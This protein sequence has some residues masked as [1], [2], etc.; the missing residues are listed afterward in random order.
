M[1]EALLLTVGS[2][3][4]PPLDA[5]QL[6]KTERRKSLEIRQAGRFTELF[7][8]RGACDQAGDRMSDD[9]DLEIGI[10]IEAFANAQGNIDILVD[11]IDPT[12]A[13]DHLQSNLGVRRQKRG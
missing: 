1:H 7:E 3:E 13:D 6:A 10:G 11:Q 8:K 4:C 5:R 9:L 2:E 12:V